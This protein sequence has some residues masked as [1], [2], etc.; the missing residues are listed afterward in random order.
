M[1]RVKYNLMTFY[2]LF[3]SALLFMDIVSGGGL[4]IDRFTCTVEPE[5][6]EAESDSDE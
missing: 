1:E 5:M 4:V 6:K 2:Y 3:S